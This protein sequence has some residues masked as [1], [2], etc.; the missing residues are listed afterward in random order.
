MKSHSRIHFRI[1]SAVGHHIVFYLFAISSRTHRTA[2]STP[3]K[4]HAIEITGI[5][6]LQT[7]SSASD[8]T[9]PVIIPDLTG[10]R[11]AILVDGPIVVRQP[12]F[13]ESTVGIGGK[14][15]CGRINHFARSRALVRSHGE[16]DGLRLQSLKTAHCISHIGHHQLVFAIF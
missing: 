12:S 9:T 14:V 8:V 15:F 10:F 11:H 6:T 4:S 13:R 2:G 16:V 3:I 5:R 1:Q 7:A